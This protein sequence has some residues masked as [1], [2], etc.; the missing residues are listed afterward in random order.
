MKKEINIIELS[1]F[2]KMFSDSTRLKI[3]MILLNEK[4]CVN[5]IATKI[6][7]SQSSVSH[8]LKI[9]RYN[10]FVKYERKGK[11]IY[12]SLADSHIKIILKYGIEHINERGLYEKD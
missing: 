5:D 7:M 3:L 2:Y 12:Y 8:Q 1:E 11:E 6:N 9:L 4:L 10:N